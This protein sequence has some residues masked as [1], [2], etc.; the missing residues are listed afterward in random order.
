MVFANGTSSYNGLEMKLEKKPGPEGISLLLSYTWAKSIDDVGGRLTVRGDPVGISRNVPL[1]ANRGLSEGNIPSRLVL[2]TGYDLPFGPGKKFLSN[3]LAG[4]VFGGWSV[5]SILALEAGP[6][7]TASIPVDIYDVGSTASLRPD[8][9]RNPNLPSSQRT[10]QRWFDTGAFALPKK[11]FTY[12][13]AGRSI[14]QG[15]GFVILDASLQRSFHTSETSRLEFR[16]EAFNAPNHTNFGFP[17]LAFG[18]SSFGVIGGAQ[19]GRSLQFGLK[20]YF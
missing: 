6:F 9:L 14:I 17:G 1:S 16:F 20:F 10:P 19:P 15:P 8:L 7:L 18:T 2:Y 11:P 5:Q 12:G 3:S 13:N 4:K